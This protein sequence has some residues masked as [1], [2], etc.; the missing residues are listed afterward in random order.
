MGITPRARP[1]APIG[2]VIKGL[3]M[4]TAGA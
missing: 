4:I 2:C 3:P 1:E